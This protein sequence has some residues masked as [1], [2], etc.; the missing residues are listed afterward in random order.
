MKRLILWILLTGTIAAALLLFVKRESDIS[1]VTAPVERGDIINTITVTGS[2]SPV[3]EV[4]VGSQLS[5]QLA[6]RLVDYNQEVKKN[7]PLARL[8]STILTAR[9]REA[10]SLV[11]VAEADVLIKEAGI[12]KAEYEL[13]NAH[14]NLAIAQ[15]KIDDAHAIHQEAKSD[16]QRKELLL[17][18]A[19][20]SRSQSD[21]ARARYHSSVAKL[22][23]E[24]LKLQVQQL[25]ILKAKLGV[26]IAK[27]GVQHAQG[28]VRQR[29]A[30]HDRAEV[31][32]E[33]TVIR[34]P[35]D[36]VVIGLDVETG[37]TV[38]AAL[39]APTLFTLAKDLRQIEVKA[40][41]D[42][43]D[44]GRVHVGQE[45]SFT[46]AAYARRQFSGNIIEIRKAPNKVE[47][48]V[49]YTVLIAAE[50]ADQTL[51]PGMT[52]TI[53]IMVESVHDVLKVPN[54]AL[55]FQP[56]E[57]V[58]SLHS[59][60]AKISGRSASTSTST[61][62]WVLDKDG[63]PAPLEISTGIMD[64][65]SS[66]LLNAALS[67]DAA[68]IVRAESVPGRMMFDLPFDW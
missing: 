9:L 17:S 32:L 34:A 29:Q 8:D 28:I 33:R 67:E 19:T 3:G 1:Y 42:E 56:P 54:A 13:K 12:L 57:D 64:D 16:F 5:G 48:V 51:F 31:E 62:V 37:Q 40:V 52:A 20:I 41:I 10:Q 49:T 59:S 2:V 50:N 63:K 30:A 27:A 68:V 45:V 38:A 14:E 24:E 44:I 46:V 58:I 6:I 18:S 60:A 21:E 47:N 25:A 35:I 4:K 43:A 53:R 36:G 26:R 66:E 23:A 11:E 55:R 15:L 39:E 7:Q 22:R 61:I 65:F